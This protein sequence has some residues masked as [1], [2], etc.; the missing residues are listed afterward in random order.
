MNSSQAQA[1]GI[2]LKFENDVR[3]EISQHLVA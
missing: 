2:N 3:I 1:F